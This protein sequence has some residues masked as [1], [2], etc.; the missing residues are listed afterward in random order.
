MKDIFYQE[1][2]DPSQD[3]IM[4]EDGIKVDLLQKETGQFLMF[5]RYLRCSCIFLQGFAHKL[6]TQTPRRV[7]A[8]SS[9]EL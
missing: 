1:R 7:L 5:A 6:V 8:P 2:R 4:G 9:R 3:D